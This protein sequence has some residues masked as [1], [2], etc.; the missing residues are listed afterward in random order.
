MATRLRVATIGDGIIGWSIAFE[1]ARRAVD[2]TVFSA[3]LH[4]SATA[5]SAGILAPDV[6][7]HAGEP[8][9][10]LGRRGL[11][12]YDDFVRRLQA[13]T[14][15]PFEYRRAGT[16]EV[17]DDD[18]RRETLSSTPQISV[19]R[20]VDAASLRE[21]APNVR[22]DAH[23][24]RLCERHG[25]VVVSSF[26]AALE[27]AAVRAGASVIQAPAHSVQPGH[28]RVTI[29][30]DQDRDFDSVVL[31]AGAWTP[32]VDPLSRTS[33]S[34][35]PVRGQLVRLR[36]GRLRGGP[37]LWGRDCYIVPWQDGT[38]LV[39]ATAED[40]GFEVRATASG[41]RGLLAA[42]EKL[43]PALADA[44]F[45]DVRVG[46]RP[47]CTEG[48]PILG[49]ADDPRIVYATGHF[50]NGVLLAPLT[51][52]LVAEYILEGVEDAAFTA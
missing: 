25:Y 8:L 35:R 3:G 27:D 22:H 44:S 7:A 30:A 33:T 2:V 26:T 48:L 50:R 43:V 29:V 19:S 24:A 49:P 51:A 28:R 20:W 38:V 16:L 39:G 45:V 34:V 12:L 41:V 15:I 17:A 9:L 4:G 5:A 32:R 23:G 18:D 1:L 52:K 31:A 6:E 14:A 11:A 36:S 42:A 21:M 37:I 46:L 40:A 13:A 10:E 47:G